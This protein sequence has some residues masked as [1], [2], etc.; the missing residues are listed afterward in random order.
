MPSP[1]AGQDAITAAAA[2]GALLG[3][4]DRDARQEPPAPAASGAERG[5]VPELVTWQ[6]ARSIRTRAIARMQA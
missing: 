1:Q 4:L 5:A 6:H 3:K 2:V